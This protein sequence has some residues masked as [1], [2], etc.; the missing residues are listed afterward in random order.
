MHVLKIQT[1]II[2]ITKHF[3]KFRQVVIRIHST[4]AEF[5][6][7]GGSLLSRRREYN[8]NY[9]NN[10]AIV[11]CPFSILIFTE[12]SPPLRREALREHTHRLC[13]TPEALRAGDGGQENLENDIKH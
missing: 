6:G 3:V 13:R 11:T 8:F 7:G 4:T 1:P 9:Y 2:R 12:L 5:E 10:I